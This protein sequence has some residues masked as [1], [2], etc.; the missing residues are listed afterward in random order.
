VVDDIRASRF[1]GLLTVEEDP[2][3]IRS[4]SGS[5]QRAHGVTSRQQALERH[6]KTGDYRADWARSRLPA[7]PSFAPTPAGRLPDCA[8][9][10]PPMNRRCGGQL[11]ADLIG[12]AVDL[13]LA[14]FG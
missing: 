14:T 8:V 1:G 4:S 3:C 11:D 6:T 13:K 12:A 2:F 9:L 7:S 5:T 10:S